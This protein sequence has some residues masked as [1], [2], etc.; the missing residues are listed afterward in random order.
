MN[1][2]ATPTATPTIAD[3]IQAQIPDWKPVERLTSLPRPTNTMPCD[4]WTIGVIVRKSLLVQTYI[5]HPEYGT[6]NYEF[7]TL[8]ECPNRADRFIVGLAAIRA[9][10]PIMGD[11]SEAIPKYLEMAPDDRPIQRMHLHL[12]KLRRGSDG[13]TQH[14]VELDQPTIDEYTTL[15]Q[16]GTALPALKVMHD[17]DGNFWPYD[18]LHTLEGLVNVEAPYA[19][20]DVI[21]GT[22]EEA[23][24]LALS[25]NAK[26]GLKRSNADKVAS[27][28]WA[29]AQERHKD[30]SNE[31]IARL[32][33]VSAPFVAAIRRRLGDEQTDR[34]VQRNGTSYQL[35]TGGLGRISLA[36]AQKL[37]EPWGDLA[38][39]W[40]KVYKLEL[41]QRGKLIANFRTADEAA[42]MHSEVTA[43][44][45]KLADFP[46]GPDRCATCIHRTITTDHPDQWYCEAKGPNNTYALDFDWAVTNNGDC[47]S[48]QPIEIP[49]LELET[50]EVI[51]VGDYAPLAD[52]LD[53]SHVA[54][55][56]EVYTVADYIEAEYKGKSGNEKY[57]P[58]N[59]IN[60][61]GQVFEKSIALD[62]ASC[63]EANRI[64]K[65]DRIYTI[66]EDGLSQNWIADTLFINPPYSMPEIERFAIKLLSQMDTIDEWIMLVNACTE[67]SWFQAVAQ[68][69]DAMLFPASRINFWYP[70]S[71]PHAI[72]GSNE[73]RQCLIYKGDNVA[74]FKALGSALG[75]VV[76]VV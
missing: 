17:A 4:G 63:E 39:C 49:A 29:I 19:I 52:P 28:T 53:L 69:S 50:I 16:N 65:A 14:R 62:P 18:G 58:P 42:Q 64:V 20:C 44:I 36:D 71:D 9:I 51:D 11:L 21:E 66:A 38:S 45:K 60:F 24:D 3:G 48:V 68:Q 22:L 32:C 31:A 54:D 1:A 56:P 76:T 15:L 67:T 10:L 59:W 27:V 73:Y 70:G 34:T 13:H 25:V 2:I 8:E 47:R 37:Y 12:S 30:K 72:K 40:H 41:R 23:Q 43:Q 46:P 61:V 57:T 7:E 74:R 35:K 26:H 5:Q 55:E 75:L 6:W 33:A